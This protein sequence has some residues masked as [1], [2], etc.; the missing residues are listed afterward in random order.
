MDGIFRNLNPNPKIYLVLIGLGL[1]RGGSL[2]AEEPANPGQVSRRIKE[3][4]RAGFPDFNGRAFQA[5]AEKPA[6]EVDPDV[7]VLPVVKVTGGG[8]VR[9]ME[10]FGAP[11]KTEAVPLVA[12]TGITEFKGKKYTVLVPTIFFIPIGF[13]FKW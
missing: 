7:L 10:G 3:A 13:S 8:N 12:G 11:L 5:P 4:V 9:R 6:G 1:L 2:F